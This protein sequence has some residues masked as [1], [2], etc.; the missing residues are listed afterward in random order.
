MDEAEQPSRLLRSISVVLE[1][2]A[3]AGAAVT[4]GIVAGIAMI[5]IFHFLKPRS[6]IQRVRVGI[7]VSLAPVVLLTIALYGR[8]QLV[9]QASALVSRWEGAESP[10]FSF[11]TLDGKQIDSSQLRGKRVLLNFWATWCV[12]CQLEIP[13]INRLLRESAESDVVV[14][15][16]SSESESKIREYLAKNPVGYPMVSVPKEQLPEPYSDVLAVPTS[17]VLDRKGVIQFVHTGYVTAAQLKATTWDADD[18]EG[19]PRE[20]SGGEPPTL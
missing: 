2:L 17:F 19:A 16:L 8:V 14:F 5:T 4:G 9:H 10:P 18:Y 12:P 13:E 3:I 7:L 6:S 15:G 20:P 1:L 11:V